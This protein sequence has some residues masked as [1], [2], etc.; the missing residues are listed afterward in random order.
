MMEAIDVSL[1]GQP[2]LRAFIT[3][4]GRDKTCTNV[5]RLHDKIGILRRLFE[6]PKSSFKRA[7]CLQPSLLGRLIL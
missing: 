2:N 6:I 4:S 3:N 7:L 1:G 5:E